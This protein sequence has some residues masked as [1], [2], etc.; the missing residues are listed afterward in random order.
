MTSNA[1]TT[2]TTRVA[3]PR[4]RG[5][6][7]GK[8]V[9]FAIAALLVI[10]GIYPG[11]NIL[12]QDPAWRGSVAV[13]QFADERIFWVVG[14][15]VI[16]VP[17]MLIAQVFW[18]V[19]DETWLAVRARLHAV[20]DRRFM[21]VA[22]IVATVLALGSAFW[23]FSRSPTTSDEVAQLWHAQMLLHGRLSLPVD[24]NPEFF[25]ID[26]VVDQ[27]RW[28]SQFP[29]GWPVV[30]AAMPFRAT[31]ALNPLLAGLVVINVYRFAARVYGTSE[32]RL[33]A[34]LGATCP[35]LLLVSGS[36]MNHT[37]VAFLT[38][39]ALAELP[40][41]IE[42]TDQRRRR[43]ALTIGASLGCAIAVRP[44]DGAMATLV[45]GA[46]MLQQA[47]A[48]RRVMLLIQ[49]AAGGA[50]PII[51][52]LIANQLTTGNPLRFGYD[53]I[54]GPNHS[55]GFHVDPTGNPHT[56]A[57][58]LEIVIA[59]LMQLNWSLFGWPVAGL[60]VVAG[61]LVAIGRLARWE[62]VLIGWI[63]AQ[64]LAYAVY[65]GVGMFFGPRY[66]FTVVPAFL[67]LTSRGIV[68]ATRRARPAVR[69]SLTAGIGASMLAGFVILRPP[70]GVVGAALAAK[71]LRLAMKQNL[72]PAIESLIGTKALIF[73]SETA[74]GRLM[75]RLWSLG[76]SRPD[77]IR[78]ITNKDH[79]SLLDAAIEEERSGGSPSDHLARLE[80][81]KTY[82]PP[83]GV[84]LVAPDP[85]FRV[86]D[87]Q[88]ITPACQLEAS[89]DAAYG[90]ALS[91]G[92]A[93]L[94][95]VIGP[96]GRIAGPIVLVADIGEH[97][98]VLRARFGDRPWYRLRL[99]PGGEP[100]V[101]PY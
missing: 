89:A 38:T 76:V 80:R 29:I 71:P 65:F 5:A 55:L 58:A 94:R 45:F 52:L 19:F 6:I 67:I 35:Y 72:D 10:L 49:A 20:S 54:W 15:V 96:D 12:F 40:A 78:L 95:N 34:V 42:G 11:P 79:C 51:G 46:F 82:T 39:L 92:P 4:V 87:E 23:V 63:E 69:R 36:Y 22:A 47:V 88:S 84:V 75:R 8:P 77:A 18:G 57:R 50:L 74:S 37:F 24:P 81:T 27:G 3:E 60:L 13:R 26:N 2:D 100:R 25:A 32:A 85:A 33:A 91:Y 73:V 7:A 64:L 83:D 99:D 9:T 16:L 43:A 1:Q 44:L 98:E 41:S 90:E 68:L 93:L 48:R 101:V 31:W 86:S 14:L 62:V 17:V 70:F 28:Y 30:L 59:Y 53:V 56:P 61:A 97:N 21:L 66:L